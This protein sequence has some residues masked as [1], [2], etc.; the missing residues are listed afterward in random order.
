MLSDLRVADV[1]AGTPVAVESK[2]RDKHYTA[3]GQRNQPQAQRGC[4]SFNKDTLY[5]YIERSP[6]IMASEEMVER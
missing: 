6:I 3:R 4:I 1:Q 2:Q 5:I